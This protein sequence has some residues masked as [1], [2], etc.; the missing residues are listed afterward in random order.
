MARPVATHLVQLT[1]PDEGRRAAVV[2]GDE[3]HLLATYRSV[4]DFAIAALQV[5]WRLRDL[6]RADDSGIALDYP[7]IHR[8]KTPWRFLPAFDHPHEPGRCLVS[9]VRGGKWQYVGSGDSLFGHGETLPPTEISA[10]LRLPEVA[11]AYVIGH[12]GVPRRVG[13][14]LGIGAARR[15]ALG[16]ELVLDEYPALEP[17][18]RLM[19][20]GREVWSRSLSPNL[21]PPV[22]LAAAEKGLFQHADHRRFGDTHVHFFGEILFGNTNCVETGEGDEGSVESRGFGRKLTT[23]IAAE[24]TAPLPAEALPL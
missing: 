9:S 20:D 7:E 17:T 21:G 2:D 8:L 23:V 13:L 11:A 22:A 16:P 1:H 24:Q 10:Q 14:A 5:G 12:N 4:F 18:S 3:L 15:S 19:R 6:L